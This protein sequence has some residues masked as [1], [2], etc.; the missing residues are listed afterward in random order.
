[1]RPP[2]RSPLFPNPPLFRSEEKGDTRAARR[3]DERPHV[4]RRGLVRLRRRA[5]RRHAPA[6]LR[7]G[8]GRTVVPALRGPPRDRRDAR[9]ARRLPGR[10]EVRHRRAGRAPL[11]RQVSRRH[12]GRRPHHL[13]GR[14][15]PPARVH[16]VS[17]ARVSLRGDECGGARR[18][19]GGG[20]R[21]AGRPERS[22]VRQA[23]RRWALLVAVALLVGGL[24]GGRWAAFETAERVWAAGLPGGS[25]Y[26]KARDFAR[27]VSGTL[28]LATEI[29]RASCRE[30]A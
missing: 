27:L 21:L 13:Q 6:P 22:R 9:A 20:R 28:L 29:G 30:R 11:R 17:G 1:M 10:A 16:L 15:G 4:L 24:V 12:A 25:A 18:L 26:L 8:A 23:A 5:V 7:G 2:P 14:V 3:G 19:P